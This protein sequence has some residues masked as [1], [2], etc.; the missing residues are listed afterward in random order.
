MKHIV[1][2][3]WT[4][5][6]GTPATKVETQKFWAAEYLRRIVGN[7]VENVSV[8]YATRERHG[9]VTDLVDHLMIMEFSG[10]LSP[11]AAG[12]KVA[13]DLQKQAESDGKLYVPPQM[14]GKVVLN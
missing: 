2:Y 1:K 9:E 5:P 12:L 11:E 7:S 3:Q 13:H 10:K 4:T 8:K 14:P 6:F